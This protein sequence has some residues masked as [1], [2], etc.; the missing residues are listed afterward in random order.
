MPPHLNLLT[1][2]W[3]KNPY[4]LGSYM[5]ARRGGPSVKV[6]TNC[7]HSASTATVK[8]SSRDSR[9][10]QAHGLIPLKPGDTVVYREA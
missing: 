6:H 10:A 2:K 3:D 9:A 5:G 1:H 4:S 8:V 7:G